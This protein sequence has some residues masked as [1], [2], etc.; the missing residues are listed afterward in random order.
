M[1]VKLV[2]YLTFDI[3]IRMSE[4]QASSTFRHSNVEYRA[5]FTEM[6]QQYCIR[7]RGLKPARCRITTEMGGY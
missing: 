5:N 4:Y 2:R 6:T 3:H 1:S 7:Y